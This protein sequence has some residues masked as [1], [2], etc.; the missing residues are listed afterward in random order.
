[1]PRAELHRVP[2]SWH[3]AFMDTPSTAI[4]TLDGDIRADPPGFDRAAFLTQLGG[5]LVVF[6]DQAFKE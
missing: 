3:F 5:E 6:F 1:M 4:P 2:N